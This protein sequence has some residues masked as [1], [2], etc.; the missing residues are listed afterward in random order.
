[1]RVVILGGTRFIGARIA[2]AL[3][4]RGD[5]VIT[6]HRGE[7]ELAGHPADRHIHSPRAAFQEISE[8][9]RALRPGALVDT[10]AMTT[11]P[12]WSPYL[13]TPFRHL[14]NPPGD[15][16]PDFS[17]DDSALSAR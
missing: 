15:T 9:I 1:M 3:A 7:H 12:D 16:D 11:R 6:A 5:E 10:C 4:E 2:S 8:R 13:T 17:P 14:A